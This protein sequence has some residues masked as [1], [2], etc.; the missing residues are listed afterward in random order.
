MAM[1]FAAGGL[2]S[3]ISSLLL[4]RQMITEAEQFRSLPAE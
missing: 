4:S 2:T 1:I 3:M